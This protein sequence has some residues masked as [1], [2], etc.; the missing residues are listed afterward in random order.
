VTREL[1]PQRRNQSHAGDPGWQ[2]SSERSI[3]PTSPDQLPG[4]IDKSVLAIGAPKRLRDKAHLKFVALQPCLVC[5]RMCCK[6]ILRAC[7]RNIDSTT[8]ENAQ[9]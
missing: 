7:Q 1:A 5:G 2:R 9:C 8:D 4:R 3:V 6:T